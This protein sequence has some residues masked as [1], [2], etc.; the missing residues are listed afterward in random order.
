M[1]ENLSP[2]K[3]A[4][5]R[6]ECGDRYGTGLLVYNGKACYAITAFHVVKKATEEHRI[7]GK[8]VDL[9]GQFS[10]EHRFILLSHLDDNA[11]DIA[12]LQL[13][14]NWPEHIE[15]YNI[16][17]IAEPIPNAPFDF[18]GFPINGNKE[19]GQEIIDG[20]IAGVGYCNNSFPNIVLS[21]CNSIIDGCSGG[22][23]FQNG[24]VVGLVLCVPNSIAGRGTEAAYGRPIHFCLEKL[25][26]WERPQIGSKPTRLDELTCNRGKEAD[27]FREHFDAA[28]ALNF[29]VIV[30]ERRQMPDSL[31]ERL[32]LEQV[33]KDKDAKLPLSPWSNKEGLKILET[34]NLRL[35][36]SE[37]DLLP[38]AP[39]QAGKLRFARILNLELGKSCDFK[40]QLLPFLEQAADFFLKNATDQ[41]PLLVFVVVSLDDGMAQKG[42]QQIRGAPNG[43]TW[44]L[45]PLLGPLEAADL[46]V[47]SKRIE[48]KFGGDASKILKFITAPPAE[49]PAPP[50]GLLSILLG[51]TAS[52]SA[53]WA[54]ESV[55]DKIKSLLK[56]SQLLPCNS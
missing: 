20:K 19:H 49:A 23:V 1:S 13:E 53:N 50:K 38:K 24:K 9:V 18:Y 33:Q 45:L 51:R 5:V 44:H 52:A 32:V 36:L 35:P 40:R 16:N 41:R 7:I 8:L 34:S 11:G 42:H 4:T 15:P 22:A 6:V 37:H 31:A 39:P 30:G 54:M 43:H 3:R 17:L 27:F 28:A 55:E 26:L 47:W 14:G 21:D 25:G 48:Q 46:S 29:F 10:H 56:E 2:I 12:L